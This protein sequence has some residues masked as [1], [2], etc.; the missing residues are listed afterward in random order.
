MTL[1]VSKCAVL[2]AYRHEHTYMLNG[3]A[4][5]AWGALRDLGVLI[6]PELDFDA[7]IAQVIKSATLISNLIFRLF[8]IKT[9]QFYLN[10]FKSLVLPKFIDCSEVWR[11]YLRKHTH[12]LE[13]V[14]KRFLRR[15]CKRCDI[16]RES[17]ELRPV[18]ELRDKEDM[19]MF[20]RNNNDTE[21][22]S[23]YAEITCVAARPLQHLKSQALN[24]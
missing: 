3:Q 12:A 5:P 19:N 14:Q 1:S 10:L 13:H 4:I 21:S 23:R 8:V 7:H 18:S 16:S 20:A 9:P 24:G 11:P 15:V 17:V 22:F 6:T 2:S